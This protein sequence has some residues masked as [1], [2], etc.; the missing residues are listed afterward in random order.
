ML[1]GAKAQVLSLTG[2]ELALYGL[3]Q[4]TSLIPLHDLK[5]GMYLLGITLPGKGIIETH[6]F[7]KL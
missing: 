3:E 7:I 6:K 2:T 5:P 1:K 4:G